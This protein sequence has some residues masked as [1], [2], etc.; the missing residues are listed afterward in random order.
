MREVW[1]GRTL[2]RSRVH[3]LSEIDGDLGEMRE[4][5]ALGLACA[6]GLTATARADDDHELAKKLTNP[7]ADLISVP[8]QFNYDQGLG[9]S[10]KGRGVAR[11]IRTLKGSSRMISGT[12][13]RTRRSALPN[14]RRLSFGG[15]R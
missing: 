9:P 5:L 3:S 6:L 12:A 2:A 14:W 8:F 11:S 1:R 7:V 10:D 13:R 4:Y 15:T